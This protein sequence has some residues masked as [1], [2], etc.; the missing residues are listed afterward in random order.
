[1]TSYKVE[2]SD[3]DSPLMTEE[4]REGK[5]E[6]IGLPVP[7]FPGADRISIEELHRDGFKDHREYTVLSFLVNIM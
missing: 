2:A 7:E 6:F 3:F 4:M 5:E 1:M